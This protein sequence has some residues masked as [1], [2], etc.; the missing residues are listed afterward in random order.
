VATSKKHLVQ[1]S[2][3]EN[4]PHSALFGGKDGLFY[5]KKFLKQAGNFLK[6]C[7]KIFMEFSPEQKKKIRELLSEYGYKNYKFGKDQHNRWRFV[8]ACQSKSDNIK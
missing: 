6:P 7:G 5:I 4:E 1:K 2:V 3:L 8:V